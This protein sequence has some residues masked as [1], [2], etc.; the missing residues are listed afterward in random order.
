L[1]TAGI[2]EYRSR[3]RH[4]LV[5]AAKLADEFVA[6]AQIEMI[7]IGED[8][9]RAEFFEGFLREGFDGS[10]R[11]DGH[12][13]GS[14]DRAVRRGQASAACTRRVGLR[15]FKRKI[16][17]E[18]VSGESPCHGRTEQCEKQIDADNNAGGF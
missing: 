4:E 17:S 8:D 11:A 16:H 12:E 1:I 13:E 3:P 9:F 2:R 15:N 18:S 6:G 14:L 10:L 5:Q 7:G